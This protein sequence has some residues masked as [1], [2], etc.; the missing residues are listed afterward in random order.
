MSLGHQPRPRSMSVMLKAQYST[1]TSDRPSIGLLTSLGAERIVVQTSSPPAPETVVRVRFALEGKS[2]TVE[3]TGVA[4]ALDEPEK[5][6]FAVTIGNFTLGEA[7]LRTFLG[8][9]LPTGGLDDGAPPPADA[10]GRLLGSLVTWAGELKPD[11]P[12]RLIDIGE[13]GL[14][15]KTADARNPG[16]LEKST[17]RMQLMV[18][19]R[20]S[21]RGLPLTGRV[22]RVDA[23]GSSDPADECWGFEIE[24]RD[25]QKVPPELLA[26]IRPHIV[27]EHDAPPEPTKQPEV[28]K[29]EGARQSAETGERR[30]SPIVLVLVLIAF[31]ALCWWLVLWR[32]DQ[33]LGPLPDPASL[34]R[35][36]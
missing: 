4:E 18:P 7:T 12:T 13:L 36:R 22:V 20:Q 25:D 17:L 10:G 15:L 11:T 35:R 30:L 14:Y 31:V 32:L 2:G 3:L 28:S 1:S 29:P 34:P 27:A 24:L 21:T 9:D 5:K 26:Q 6:G 33:I 19:L 16:W 23:P 8:E